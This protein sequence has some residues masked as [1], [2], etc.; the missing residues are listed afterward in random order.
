MKLRDTP[1][2]FA[3][4][5]HCLFRGGGG[6]RRGL[7]FEDHNSIDPSTVDAQTPKHKERVLQS[8]V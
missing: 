6:A 7:F 2:Q 4:F 3:A 8:A 1:V 5:L